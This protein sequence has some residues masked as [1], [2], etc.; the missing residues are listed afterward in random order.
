MLGMRFGTPIPTLIRICYHPDAGHWLE[1]M[2]GTDADAVAQEYPDDVRRARVEMMQLAEQRGNIT[3]TFRRKTQP[4]TPPPG[5]EPSTRIV[6]AAAPTDAGVKLPVAKPITLRIAKPASAMPLQVARPTAM[7]KN[8]SVPPLDPLPP[9]NLAGTADLPPTS[10]QTP[11]E[12]FTINEQTKQRLA[13]LL[14]ASRRNP[15]GNPTTDAN[16]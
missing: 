3:T 13:Q 9:A 14:A 1:F 2:D 10:R 4:P 12:V 11:S 6:K 8:V 7:P 16:D 5:K 15:P